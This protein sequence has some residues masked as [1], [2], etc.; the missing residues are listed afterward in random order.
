MYDHTLHRGRKHFFVI[1]HKLLVQKK[2]QKF[3]LKAALKWQ[4][5]N[6]SA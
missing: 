4:T 5:K 1:V 6:Y 2:Y 3:I